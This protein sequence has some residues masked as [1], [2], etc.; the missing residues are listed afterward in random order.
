MPDP[1]A[2]LAAQAATIARLRGVDSPEARDDVATAMWDQAGTLQLLDLEEDSAAVAD[3]L[4][5]FTAS[6]A[7]EMHPRHRHDAAT[8]VRPSGPSG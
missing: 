3:E 2:E 6:H 7:H 4:L 5:A 8:G 1:A